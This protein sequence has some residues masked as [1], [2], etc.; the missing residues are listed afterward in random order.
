MRRVALI[1]ALFV[2]TSATEA[3]RGARLFPVRGDVAGLGAGTIAIDVG[4][5]RA[6][7]AGERCAVIDA[8]GLVG[9]A[10]ID[11]VVRVADDCEWCG[12]PTAYALVRFDA[13]PSR[14]PRHDFEHH[15]APVAA[16]GLAEGAATPVIVTSEIDHAAGRRTSVDLDA[17]GRGDLAL[18][19][20]EGAC[21]R[22]ARVMPRGASPCDLMRRAVCESQAQRR[23]DG[24]R[25]TERVEHASCRMDGRR[26][27][28][29]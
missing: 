24:W 14:A 28:E 15:V 16:C 17:D 10:R 11:Q 7:R 27:L 13:P 25:A 20:S 29:L 1:V 23:G 19:S 18:L 9:T 5:F 3:Q 21:P 4:G 26:E 2:V 8:D 12:A 22:P 6:P